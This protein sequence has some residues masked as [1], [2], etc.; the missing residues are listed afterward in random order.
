[1]PKTKK[2]PNKVR[3]LRLKQCWTQAEL[4]SKSGLTGVTISFIE[5]GITDPAELS[6]AKLA[7]AFGK[8][9][10]YLFPSS[11]ETHS[12]SDTDDDVSRGTL[13]DTAQEYPQLPPGETIDDGS[14]EE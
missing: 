10:P 1:M 11:E 14:T 13:H 6:K 4:A 7:R 9:I 8:S 3:A 5:R 12:D 2:Y